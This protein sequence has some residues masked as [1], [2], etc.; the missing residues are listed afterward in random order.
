MLVKLLFQDS[1][2]HLKRDHE[3]AIVILTLL[4]GIYSCRLKY[5]NVQTNYV[6]FM[7][8][9]KD[10]NVCKQLKDSAVV[11]AVFVD[12]K[13]FYPWTEFAVNINL[14]LY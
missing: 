14:R 1:A 10:L 4:T 11:F 2:L 12:A 6:D 7:A 3:K 5:Y 8:Q 9:S 13:N